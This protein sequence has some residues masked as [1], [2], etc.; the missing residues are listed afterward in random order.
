MYRTSDTA[1][2]LDRILVRQVGMDHAD[3]REHCQ[4]QHEAARTD[5]LRLINWPTG[6]VRVQS[7]RS[8]RYQA[9]S[10]LYNRVTKLKPFSLAE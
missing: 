8:R 9:A 10:V 2:Y 5:L 1:N 7:G 4:D 6:S 3:C